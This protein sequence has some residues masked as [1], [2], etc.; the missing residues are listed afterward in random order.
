MPLDASIAL[1]VKPVQMED[2]TQVQARQ[3][4]LRNLV[5]QNQQAEQANQNQQSLADA[6]RNAYGPD[7]QLDRSQLYQGIA[8]RGIGYQIPGL[9]K[10]FAESDK[11]ITDQQTA[12]FDLAKKRLDASAGALSSLIALGPN[13]THQHIINTVA[14]LVQN[15][16]MDPDQGAQ[17]VRSLPGNPAALP[18]YLQQ[19]GLQVLDAK[20]RLEALMPKIEYKDTG[21]QLQPVDMNPI[22]NG[23]KAPLLTKTASPDAQLQAATTR[24]GQDIEAATARRGQDFGLNSVEKSETGDLM[25]VN[26]QTGAGRPVLGLDGQPINLG[27]GQRDAQQA[28]QLINQATPLI[29]SATSSYAGQGIDM[30][31]GAFGIA[32]PGS[33]DAAKLR[34]IEGALVSKMPKMSGPQSDKDVAMYRQMAGQIGD[35]SVPYPQKLAALDAVREIQERYAKVPK[36]SSVPTPAPVAAPA[37][38]PPTPGIPAGWNVIAH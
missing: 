5:L 27:T 3:V 8:Q 13:V 12:Q 29:K 34:A 11:A 21:G 38:V 22:T 2:P 17:L 32:T 10:Q 25:I 20:S 15:K 9:Q 33:I 31:A 23:G 6:F 19:K 24:R 14:D 35:P 26:K 36:G 30:L 1:G 28:L 37:Q 16:M 18:A 4:Q 7:G